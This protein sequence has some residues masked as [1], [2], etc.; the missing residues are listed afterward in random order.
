MVDSAVSDLVRHSERLAAAAGRAPSL[1]N[2]QPWR[3][4]V[5][6]ASVD[7]YADRG[8]HLPVA[9]PHGRQMYLGLGAALFALRLTLGD[10]HCACRVRLLPDSDQPDLAARLEAVGSRDPTPTEQQLL[11]QLQHRRSVRTPFTDDGVPVPVRV[12]LGEH[13]EAEGT[14]LR[15]V[16][17]MGER[18]GVA[19]LVLAAERQQ[20][21]DPAYRAELATWTSAEVLSAGAG[22]PAEAF[23]VSAVAGHA[24]PFPLRDFGGGRDRQP[25]PAAAG[26]LEQHPLVAVLSSDTDRPVDWLVGGQALMR[27]L[28]AASSAGLV[29]SQLNQPV[30]IPPLRQRLRDELRLAGWPQ[31]VLRLGYPAGPLPPPTPRRPIADVLL[32]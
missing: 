13:A 1:H 19:D 22:V 6:P 30:E 10:L 29:S 16:E 20:Q 18:R 4:G 17:T 32:P 3:L 24:A 9:D 21:A 11:A 26:P 7:L 23:G 12:A 2:A 5:A 25:A 8:R 27:V 15:W 28:L 31:V 14:E